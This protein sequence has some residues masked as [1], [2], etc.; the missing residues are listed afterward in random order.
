M[1]ATRA[2]YS[3]PTVNVNGASR[4]KLYGSSGAMK[5]VY[6]S[7]LELNVVTWA[8]ERVAKSGITPY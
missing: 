6:N 7:A 1:C 5:Y 4:N 8:V 3:Y 2:C